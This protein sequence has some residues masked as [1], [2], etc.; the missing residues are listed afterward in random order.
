[1]GFLFQK[2]I[3]KLSSSESV[4]A[5]PLIQNHSSYLYDHQTDE[6]FQ[7]KSIGNNPGFEFQNIPIQPKL[8]VSHS[9][10]P[11]EKE[12]DRVSDQIMRMSN[13]RINTCL[14]SQIN[15]KCSSCKMKEDEELKIYRKSQSSTGLEVSNETVNE[16][17]TS[18]GRSL[19]ESTKSFMEPRFGFNFSDVRIHDDSKANDLAETVNARAFTYGN[20]IF[21]AKNESTLDKKLMAHELTHVVQ[22]QTTKRI[23]NSNTLLQRSEEN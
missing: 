15:R 20:E 16:I 12:A 9:D 13:P 19:D 3:S 5:K 6:H 10:D 1:M 17:N 14:D 4:F 22:Q 11:Y 18:T 7:N 2:K 21:I 23:S 8:K